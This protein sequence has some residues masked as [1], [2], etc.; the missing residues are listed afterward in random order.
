MMKKNSPE[1]DFEKIRKK[2]QEKD[3]GRFNEPHVI[4]LLHEKASLRKTFLSVIKNTP[5]LISEI[6]Q[7][8]LL[9]KPTCYSKLHK[10]I[11]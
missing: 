2:L 3:N 6:S 10:L 4:R 5:A 1:E 9:T 11:Y 8:S 7:D